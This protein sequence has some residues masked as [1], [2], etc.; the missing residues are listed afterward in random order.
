MDTRSDDDGLL[1][2]TQTS[3]FC[4][5]ARKFQSTLINDPLKI[6]T[7]KLIALPERGET[8]SFFAAKA[9]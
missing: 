9:A 6:F 3:V 2:F 5:P 7:M 1:V 4:Q 8:L